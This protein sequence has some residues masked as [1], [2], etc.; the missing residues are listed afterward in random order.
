M[1]QRIKVVK[2]VSEISGFCPELRFWHKHQLRKELDAD[3]TESP[4]NGS[5]LRELIGRFL[6]PQI[7]ERVVFPGVSVSVQ[8]FLE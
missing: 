8:T 4:G 7:N 5:T 3:V 2:V 6:K 1:K